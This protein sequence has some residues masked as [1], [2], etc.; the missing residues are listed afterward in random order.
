MVSINASG[1]QINQRYRDLAGTQSASEISRTAVKACCLGLSG[2]GLRRWQID[3]CGL[4]YRRD[5][6]NRLSMIEIK[7][8]RAVPAR[9][10]C[11][12]NLRCDALS[13]RAAHHN[14]PGTVL[15]RWAR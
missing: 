11:G 13:G 7:T 9:K 14:Q 3:D 5:A 15:L 2:L 12:P 10:K 8:K 4:Q 6:P 1:T